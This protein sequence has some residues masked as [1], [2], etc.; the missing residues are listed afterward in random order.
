[1][2][3]IIKKP[4][5]TEKA[6]RNQEQGQYVFEVDPRSNKIQ[7]KHAIEKMFEVNIISIRTARV[8]GK[9]K[10]RFTRK[11]IMKGKTALKKKAFIT[12]KQG[13]SIDVVGGAAG[14]E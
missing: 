8:K 11:G 4:I 9:V 12:L 3:E 1:M 6:M 14:A 10:S 7:I 13:Q 5:V 2:I